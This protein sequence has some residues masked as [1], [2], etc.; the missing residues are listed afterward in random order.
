V[1]LRNFSIPLAFDFLFN[2]WSLIYRT[3]EL[4][5]NFSKNFVQNFVASGRNLA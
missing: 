5:E 2:L 4:C 1:R 3:A